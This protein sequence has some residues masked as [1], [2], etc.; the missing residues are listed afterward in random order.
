MYFADELVQIR[1]HDPRIHHDGINPQT[2][3]RRH[4]KGN[5]QDLPW[6]SKAIDPN[7]LDVKL[8]VGR[9]HQYRRILNFFPLSKIDNATGLE[10][11]SGDL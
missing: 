2:S 5:E 6:L 9:D 11:L 10:R 8:L 1:G 7:K 4:L 3:S